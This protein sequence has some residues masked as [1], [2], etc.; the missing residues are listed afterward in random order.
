ML[1]IGVTIGFTILKSI[2]IILENE[3]IYCNQN[4]YW[5]E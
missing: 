4:R 1:L 3:N 5:T 2:W